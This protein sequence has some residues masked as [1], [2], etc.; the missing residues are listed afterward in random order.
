MSVAIQNIQ[1]A[2][3]EIFGTPYAGRRNKVL[4]TYTGM[5]DAKLAI[6]ELRRMGLPAGAEVLFVVPN[7]MIP[8]SARLRRSGFFP[9]SW[10]LGTQVLSGIGLAGD[11][12]TEIALSWGADMVVVG[13]HGN[14][15]VEPPYFAC[16]SPGVAA[17]AHCSVRIARANAFSPS[18][19]RI[20]VAVDGS[21]GAD[22]AVRDIAGRSWEPG[23]AVRVV[24]VEERFPAST[25]YRPSSWANV[26][27]ILGASRSRN[28]LLAIQEAVEMLTLAGLEV[29]TEIRRGD[30]ADEILEAGRVWDAGCVV[31]GSHGVGQA[32]RGG[33]TGAGLGAVAEALARRAPFSVEIVRGPSALAAP[34]GTTRRPLQ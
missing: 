9:P 10:H 21:P 24:T 26:E 14:A 3:R 6:D 12:A 30:P 29:S 5:H 2:R 18:T 8:M 34:R 31:A 16:S 13:S 32:R 1:A 15:N 4:V 25:I 17:H 19:P 11:E 7:T 27:S 23:T 22:D 28:A 20:L 33:M